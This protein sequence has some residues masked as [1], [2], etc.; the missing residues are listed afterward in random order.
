M[1][2]GG[3]G[4]PKPTVQPTVSTKVETTDGA[5]ARTGDRNALGSMYL[6]SRTRT[7]GGVGSSGFGGQ[8]Q[9]LG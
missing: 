4:A 8:K 5:R 2:S 6:Q 1:G 3:G 9:T 7:A